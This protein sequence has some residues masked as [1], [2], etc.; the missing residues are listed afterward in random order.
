MLDIFMN[1]FKQAFKLH[2]LK[3]VF[4]TDFMQQIKKAWSRLQFTVQISVAL[5]Q[6]YHKIKA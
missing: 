5:C 3:I 2:L 4:P 1:F 6:S